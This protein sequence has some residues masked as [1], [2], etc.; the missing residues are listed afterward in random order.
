MLPQVFL[1]KINFPKEI[2]PCARFFAFVRENPT[3]EI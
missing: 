3:Q 2:S 1:N